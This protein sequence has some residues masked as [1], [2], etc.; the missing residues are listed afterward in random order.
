M[1]FK[2]L[3]GFIGIVRMFNDDGR[4]CAIFII[5]EVLFHVRVCRWLFIC[6]ADAAYVV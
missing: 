4:G 6:H 2:G 1:A 3:H 5:D